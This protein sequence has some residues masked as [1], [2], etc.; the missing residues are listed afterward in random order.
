MMQT[1]MK[2][3]SSQEDYLEAI[4]ALIRQGRV[5]RVRDI[6]KRLGVGKPA[7]TAALKTLAKRELVNYDPY[8]FIT[9]T[10]RGQAA[11]ERIDDWHVT[12]RRFLQRVLGLGHNVAEANACRMEHCADEV[13]LRRLRC[14]GEFMQ[15]AADDADTPQEAFQ[16]FMTGWTDDRRE[17]RGV[18]PL[19]VAGIGGEQ[20]R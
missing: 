4:L 8:Q 10:E 15:T 7:V 3:T 1:A 2:L 13:V 14:L 11:A 12:L 17:D 9:L 18:N 6:A 20:D 5:A 16:R 19:D